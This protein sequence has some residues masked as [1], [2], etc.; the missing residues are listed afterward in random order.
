MVLLAAL[1]TGQN[2][3]TYAQRFG[4]NKVL[5]RDTAVVSTG[6]ALPVMAAIMVLVS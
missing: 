3:F 6:L 4:V 5:A 2:V 1:P